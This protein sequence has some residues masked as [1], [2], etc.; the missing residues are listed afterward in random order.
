MA[1]RLWQL[2]RSE[3]ALVFPG[4]HGGPMNYAFVLRRI[5][6]PAPKNAGVPW[7]GF[8][9]LRHTCATWLFRSREQGGLGLNAKQVQGWLGHH[10]AAFTFSTY[11]HLL[12][13]DLP[14]P[15]GGQLWATR[16]TES[17]RDEE[18]AAE[19]IPA[20]MQAFS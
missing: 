19:A 7:M 16:A 13:D 1:Q 3:D 15:E 12:P 2:R 20:V 10:S 5:L 11:V 6:K 14:E 9:T 17:G 4:E 8:H 18:E